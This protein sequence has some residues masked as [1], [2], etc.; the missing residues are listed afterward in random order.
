MHEDARS[1]R[2]EHHRRHDI[3]RE[4]HRLR[5][6]SSSRL[7]TLYTGTGEAGDRM[8]GVYFYF[9]LVIL[10]VYNIEAFLVHMVFFFPF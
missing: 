7:F 10:S 5:W 8:V 9:S 4:L 1:V 2:T 3:G 6:S